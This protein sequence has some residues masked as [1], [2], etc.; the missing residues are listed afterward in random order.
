MFQTTRAFASRPDHHREWT[1]GSGKTN[2][3]A[4]HKQGT[5]DKYS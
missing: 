1:Y 3:V 2:S 5:S 4:S